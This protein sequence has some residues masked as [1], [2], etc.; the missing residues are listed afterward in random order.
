MV[1]DKRNVQRVARAGEGAVLVFLGFK[2]SSEEEQ[3]LFATS[4][5]HI[6]KSAKAGQLS[7]GLGSILFYLF[8]FFL[9]SRFFM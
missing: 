2:V 6:E 4:F 1:G 8:L 5:Y 7:T 9:Y 3:T